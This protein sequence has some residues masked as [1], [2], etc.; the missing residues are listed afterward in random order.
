MEAGKGRMRGDT[1][2]EA[3]SEEVRQRREEVERLKGA[4]FDPRVAETF[5][6]VPETVWKEMRTKTERG[7]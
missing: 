7:S 2:R 4:Q 1:K 6:R 5:L 3:T